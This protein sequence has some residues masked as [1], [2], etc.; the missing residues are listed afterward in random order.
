VLAAVQSAEVPEEN[1][2]DRAI[3]PVVAETMILAVGSGK[4]QVGERFDIHKVTRRIALTP[5]PA[6]LMIGG[7]IA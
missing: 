4:H 2:D 6:K 3:G 1:E 5:I 7:Q